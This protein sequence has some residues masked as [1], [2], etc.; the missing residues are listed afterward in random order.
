FVMIDNTGKKLWQIKSKDNSK[1]IETANLLYTDEEN[2]ILTVESKKGMS[3]KDYESELRII[4]VDAGKVVSKTQFADN[5]YF[6]LPFGV[7]YDPVAEK[8]F[9]F[10]EYYEKKN[11]KANFKEK[12]GFFMVEMGKD[13]KE[14]ALKR[15][16]WLNDF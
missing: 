4:A 15:I 13:G 12:E 11:G 8:Y 9:V 2:V 3:A 14:S 10:G 1:N 16:S 5:N 7:D 6:N